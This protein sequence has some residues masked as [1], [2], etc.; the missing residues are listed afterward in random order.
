MSNEINN[1]TAFDEAKKLCADGLCKY[2]IST[3]LGISEKE[4]QRQLGYW[5]LVA[6]S[7]KKRIEKLIN[8]GTHISIVSKEL[9]CT[10]SYIRQVLQ[11]I[12][13][14]GVILVERVEKRTLQDTITLPNVTINGKDFTKIAPKYGLHPL[15][16]NAIETLYEVPDT[17]EKRQAIGLQRQSLW[18]KGTPAIRLLSCYVNNKPDDESWGVELH[19][20]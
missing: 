11:T 10:T 7:K 4:C 20:Q 14:S 8:D 13:G 19:S 9:G 6:T 1:S 3:I 16:R 15:Q 17:V 12:A 18:R 5:N 2:E